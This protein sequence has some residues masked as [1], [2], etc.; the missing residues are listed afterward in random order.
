MAVTG[1]FYNALNSD[2]KYNAEQM[3]AIFD[4]VINDGIFA[5]IGDTFSVYASRDFVV[6]VGT[7]RA[8]FNS[9]W[10]YNDALLPVELEEPEVL[11]DRIDAVVIEINTEETV[12]ESSIKVVKGTPASTPQRPTMQHTLFVHQYPLAYIN[13]PAGSIAITQ[14][15]ITSMIGTSSCPYITGILQ[16]Q[17]IDNIVAQWGAQW[18]EWFAATTGAGEAAMQ[19]MI[20]Q[21]NLWFNDETSSDEFQFDQWF[22]QMKADFMEWYENI[23]AILEPDVASALASRVASLEKNFEDLAQYKSVFTYISD[24]SD[25]DLL[26]SYG[27]RIQGRTV[28][29][30]SGMGGST[31]DDISY[32]NRFSGLPAH[33]VQGALDSLGSG[34]LKKLTA[35]AYADDW[36]EHSD[37]SPPTNVVTVERLPYN[38]EGFVGL[39]ADKATLDQREAARNGVISCIGQWSNTVTLVADGQTPIF[40]IPILIYYFGGNENV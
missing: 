10:I 4:G 13:R 21:W 12:R 32:D 37:G 31:A 6:T 20:D 35:T 5:S 26:D 22:L 1:G 24:A 25:E 2:R 8:W 16:V 30:G 18:V 38:I 7:G 3:S 34:V 15:Q 27:S 17:N 40:D 29:G 23:Q 14:S 9:K 28:F 19:D 11:L 39:D 36:E 33:T